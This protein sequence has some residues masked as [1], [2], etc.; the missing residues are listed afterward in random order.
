MYLMW[1]FALTERKKVRQ[2]LMLI[3]I[4][5]QPLATVKLHGRFN[6]AIH[7]DAH[8]SSYVCIFGSKYVGLV[9]SVRVF[10]W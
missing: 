3:F 5:K 4:N 1:A 6:E 8:D 7:R 10:D 9:C 2:H